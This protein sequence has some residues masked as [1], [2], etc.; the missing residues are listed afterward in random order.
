[1][2]EDLQPARLAWKSDG[3]MAITWKDGTEA[4]FSPAFLR[5]VCPCAECQGTHGT[6][7]KAFKIVTSQQVR[8]AHKQTVIE[9]VNPVGSYAISFTWGDGHDHG[10]YTWAFLHSHMTSA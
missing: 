5:S 10:I 9:K 4:V 8:T 6:V 2:T 7:P 1:M 3:A